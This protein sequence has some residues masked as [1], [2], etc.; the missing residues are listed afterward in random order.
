MSDNRDFDMRKIPG[1][2]EMLASGVPESMDLSSRLE[3]LEQ[4]E[5][6]AAAFIQRLIRERDEARVNAAL[7]RQEIARLEALNGTGRRERDLAEQ[8]LT[9]VET[10]R[11]AAIRERDEARAVAREILAEQGYPHRI[12]QFQQ[13]NPWLEEEPGSE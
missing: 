7:L 1:I 3:E 12:A 11:L 2:E 5:D 9:R 4:K 13:E 6:F 10:E 8:T